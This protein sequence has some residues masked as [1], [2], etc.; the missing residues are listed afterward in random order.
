MFCNLSRGPPNLNGMDA[1]SGRNS[2]GAN[3]YRR[4]KREGGGKIRS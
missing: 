1:E 2:G 4:T 3:N